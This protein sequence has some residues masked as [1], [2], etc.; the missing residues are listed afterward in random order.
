MGTFDLD[1]NANV[2]PLG[3]WTDSQTATNARVKSMTTVKDTATSTALNQLHSTMLRDVAKGSAV[4][5]A[6]EDE[7]VENSLALRLRGL[8]KMKK[9]RSKEGGSL[10]TYAVPTI[11]LLNKAGSQERTLNEA[12]VSE[13]MV[14]Q[15]TVVD[16]IQYV[17]LS[18]FLFL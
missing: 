10:E 6:D 1:S 8:Q 17:H 15:R 13:L 5:P 9:I 12:H 11:M 3:T 18:F 2:K 16:H 14:R 4:S 7:L